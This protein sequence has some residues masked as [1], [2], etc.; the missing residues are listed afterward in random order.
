MNGRLRITRFPLVTLMAAASIA[1][2]AI[3]A[4]QN[5]APVY[6]DQSKFYLDC[7]ITEVVEGDS[8]D[9]YLVINQYQ[10][11]LHWFAYWHTNAVTA[12]AEDYVHQDSGA[13][14]ASY[15]ERVAM[16][17]SRTVETRE[18]SLVEGNETFTAR[19][20]PVDNVVD[21]DDPTRDE[22]CEITIIDDD[23][24]ITDVEVSSSPSRGDTYGVGETIEIS[25]TFSTAVEVDGNPALGL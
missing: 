6:A 3:F 14:W 4:L 9:V 11:W 2:I 1:I 8:I 15:S 24:N 10:D 17:A 20:S 7:P 23:P 16:R 22:K 18:D 12:G 25:A 19:F 13:I 21:R 5:E